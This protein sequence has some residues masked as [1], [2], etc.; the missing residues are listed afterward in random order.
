[1]K[2]EQYQFLSEFFTAS[3]SRFNIIKALHDILPAIMMMFYPLQLAFLLYSEGFKSEI[4]L[5]ATLVPLAVLIFVT[6]L[7]YVINAKRPYEVYNYS[8]AIHK[9][10]K[11]K[12][13]PSRHTASAFIIAMTFLYV[14]TK[15]GIIMLVLA[16]LIGITRVLSG[17]HFIKDVV[18][19]AL[20]SILT[21]IVCFFIF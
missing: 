17:V 12:S 14:D 11:G 7:R 19:G 13:F 2:E 21:G 4:F 5:K 20:I 15:I 10:T 6:I 3:K 9:N 18:S 1:M 16:T 8:P